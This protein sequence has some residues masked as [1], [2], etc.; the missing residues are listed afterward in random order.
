MAYFAVLRRHSNRSGADVGS[1]SMSSEAIEIRC[2]QP[3]AARWPVMPL[4]TFAVASA[5]WFATFALRTQSFGPALLVGS[6]GLLLGAAI[7][8]YSCWVWSSSFLRWDGAELV[9]HEGFSRWRV[10]PPKGLS[11]KTARVR[12]GGQHSSFYLWVLD[13][14]SFPLLHIKVKLWPVK[15]LRTLLEAIGCSPADLVEPHETTTARK[16]R[17]DN[18][19]LLP[20]WMA[21]QSELTV[22][23]AVLIV[24]LLVAVF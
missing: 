3:S 13:D 17:R 10:R 18:K 14:S 15:E 9:V 23:S 1:L 19:L 6:T 20:F 11:A 7:Y 22:V 16:L 12:L 24:T 21:H 5:I 4:L 2:A 8:G